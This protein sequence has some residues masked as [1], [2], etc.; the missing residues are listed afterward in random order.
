MMG[1]RELIGGKELTLGNGEI[2]IA[3]ERSTVYV[4]PT[5]IVHYIIDHYYLPPATF[6]EAG[7]PARSRPRA[8]TRGL[9]LLGIACPRTPGR[10]DN[11]GT[12]GTR[13]PTLVSRSVET[14]AIPCCPFQPAGAKS[15]RFRAPSSKT[16][17]TVPVEERPVAELV[18]AR[19]TRTRGGT[20]GLEI[21]R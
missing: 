5:M 19:R 14:Q 2:H 17:K 4:A 18:E 20:L 10:W 21:R 15:R 9:R 12:S 11:S 7:P 8:P 1:G 16:D 6:I 13:G 3:A